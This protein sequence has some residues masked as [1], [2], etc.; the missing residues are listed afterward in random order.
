[1]ASIP[2]PGAPAAESEPPWPATRRGG[3]SSPPL[4]WFGS[5]FA[6]LRH[7]HFRILWIGTACSHLAFFMSTVVQSVVAFD[8]EGSNT[9]VGAVVF[10]Q[11]LA[12]ATLGPLGGAFADRWPKRL[13]V[14]SSQAVPATVF[15]TLALTYVTG[16]ISVEWVAG[17]SFLIGVTFAF[18]GPAR[19]ALIVD[20]VP[21]ESRGNAIALSQVASTGSQVLGPGL[22]G[23]L[24]YWS[25]SGAGGAYA[26]MSGLYVVASALLLLLPRSRMRGDAG[27]TH[28]LT[29]VAAGVRYTWTQARLRLLVLLYVCVIMLGFPYVTVMPGLVENALGEP[30]ESYAFLSLVAAAGA[31]VSSLN[32][33]RFADH[34]RAIAMFAAMGLVFALGLFALAAAPSYALAACAMLVVGAGFGGFMTLN[35]AL[36][37][38]AADPAFFGRV[39]SLTMLAFGCFGLM[40]L[41]IGLLADAIGERG[42]LVVMAGAVTTL[43][44]TIGTA[45]RS[46]WVGG[47]VA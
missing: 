24:L 31:L 21:E 19:A 26:A 41:P 10:A 27:D 16:R 18:L 42:A 46:H 23:V 11:G 1:M 6:A 35:G 12:M 40:G 45:I 39:M 29:D 8:L 43:V 9:A 20:L 47:A 3:L 7:R 30:A 34:D 36:I 4:G 28:V 14:G 22:A 2:T 33:A 17:G 25:V 5:T 38:R 15:A 13:V 37:I 44:A 32:V